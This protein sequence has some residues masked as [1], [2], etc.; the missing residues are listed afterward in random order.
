MFIDL[1]D[2]LKVLLLLPKEYICPGLPQK[3]S[4]YL[5]AVSFY[6]NSGDHNSQNVTSQ[7]N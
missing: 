2:E 7:N 5:L 3:S 4:Y 6:C 1:E